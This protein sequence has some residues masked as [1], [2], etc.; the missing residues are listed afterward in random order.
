MTTRTH[1]SPGTQK[2]AARKRPPG[3]VVFV[4]FPSCPLCPCVF[5][6]KPRISLAAPPR[7][8]SD[9]GGPRPEHGGRLPA[10]RAAGPN[11][12]ADLGTPGRPRRSRGSAKRS[13]GLSRIGAPARGAFREQRGPATSGD[14]ISR[15]RDRR[16]RARALAENHHRH[17]P[18]TSPQLEPAS[19]TKRL[20]FFGSSKTAAAVRSRAPIRGR[21]QLRAHPP[22][23]AP[24]IVRLFLCYIHSHMKRLP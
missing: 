8:G 10:N 19:T 7:P 9:H 12:S 22:S 3:F 6:F 1:R 18:S 4:L 20:F 5:D 17:E 14:G 2:G 11:A 21:R 16:R 23:I 15:K 13:V 24:G